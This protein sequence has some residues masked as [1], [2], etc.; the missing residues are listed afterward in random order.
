MEHVPRERNQEANRLSQLAMAGYETLPEAT[1]VEQVEKKAFQTNEVMSND[2]S[3][4]GVG[5]GGDPWYQDVLDF[6]STGVLPVD[7]PLANKIHR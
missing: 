6:L 4:G 2:A 3:E 7:P 1:M 5:G